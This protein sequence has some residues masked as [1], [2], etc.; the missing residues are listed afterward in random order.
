MGEQTDRDAGVLLVATMDTKGSEAAFVASAI[1]EAGI[2]VR[3]M[4]AGIRGTCTHPVLVSREEVAREAGTTLEAVQKIG[5]EG[6]ALGAM[7]RGAVPIARRFYHE[8]RVKGVFGIGGSM[9]TTLGTAVMRAFPLGVP[10]VMVTTMASR[11]TRAFVG[12]RDLLMLHSVC[13]LSGLNRITRAVLG[14]GAHAMAGMVRW[15]ELH[16]QRDERPLAVIST[17]GTTEVCAVEI[18]RGLEERGYE[19]VV[20]HTVGAGGE[21]LEELIREQDVAVLVDLSL[22]ELTDHRFGGDYDAGPERGRSALKKGVPTILVP[23]NVDFLVAGAFDKAVARFPGRKAHAHNSAITV[24][25]A[26]DEEIEAVGR[27]V[28]G[29]CAGATGPVKILVPGDGLSAFDHPEGPLYSP[30]GPEAFLRGLNQE[31]DGACPVRE[32]PAHI[33]D[34]AFTAAV[35]EVFDRITG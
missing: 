6:E 4:D 10:K 20:F 21:A 30:G 32:V 2:Q 3:I 27:V 13:D 22:H 29:F 35:L 31:L 14:N 19:V 17:L 9:G 7:I 11:D 25:R 12:T 33:N 23:G 24:I 5:H 18:R 28:A 8:G 1:Q 34:P 16:E 26:A 15:R